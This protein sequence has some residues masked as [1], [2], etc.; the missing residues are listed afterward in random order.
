MTHLSSLA[1]TQEELDTAAH[2]LAY[3]GATLV[4]ES[5]CP[6]VREEM[7]WF[8]VTPQRVHEVA[9]LI[10]ADAV[11]YLEARGLLE[12]HDDNPNWV[13]LNHESEASR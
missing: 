7:E 10:V 9:K 12:R 13:T 4:I 1:L 5:A 2:H 8:D 6:R 11:I 3:E